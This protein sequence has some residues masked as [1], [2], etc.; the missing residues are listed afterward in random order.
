MQA[1]AVTTHPGEAMRKL[2]LESLQV[3]S[4]ET[5]GAAPRGRGTVQGAADTNDPKV[6]GASNA[7]PTPVLDCTY[8]C[9]V[10]IDTCW[11]PCAE[12]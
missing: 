10:F 7:C 12:P 4:F 6:C 5:T 9:T 2:K 3:E 11:G 8:G 1:S